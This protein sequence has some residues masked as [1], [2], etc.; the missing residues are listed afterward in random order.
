MFYERLF[1]NKNTP[2]K[3]D[4]IFD[5]AKSN[6]YKSEDGNFIHRQYSDLYIRSLEEA[7]NEYYA[8]ITQISFSILDRYER[9]KQQYG[10]NEPS[11]NQD[12]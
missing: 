11:S 8:K 2:L 3:L 10:N 1:W 4:T 7:Q 9:T 12:S 5:L 6:P